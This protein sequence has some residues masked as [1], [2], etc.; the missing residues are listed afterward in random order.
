MKSLKSKTFW[1]ITMSIIFSIISLGYSI[2]IIMTFIK[3]IFS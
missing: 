2:L 3:Y 1:G